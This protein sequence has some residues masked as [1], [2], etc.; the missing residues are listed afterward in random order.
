MSHPPTAVKSSAATSSERNWVSR[1]SSSAASWSIVFAPRTSAPCV[2]LGCTP[3]SQTALAR[4]WS[5]E[6]SPSAASAGRESRPD[7]T[8]SRSRCGSRD[9]RIGGRS[10]AVPLAAGVHCS[11]IAPFGM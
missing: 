8:T 9:A 11:M 6:P 7:R 5:P 10:K 2:R 1:P 4:A 3:V